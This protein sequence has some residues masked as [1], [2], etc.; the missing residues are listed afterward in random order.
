MQHKIFMKKFMGPS[1]GYGTE[2]CT[3]QIGQGSRGPGG[4]LRCRGPAAIIAHH[5]LRVSSRVSF[6]VLPEVRAQVVLASESHCAH[7]TCEGFA[8]D[9]MNDLV[10]H[11]L[12]VH[13]PLKAHVLTA[14]NIF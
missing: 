13:A 7:V 8:H 6:V 10:D 5:H 3:I 9:R 4:S 12:D 11:A 1:L 2:I 14:F